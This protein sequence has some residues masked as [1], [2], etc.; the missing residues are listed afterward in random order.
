MFYWNPAHAV[1][2]INVESALRSEFSRENSMRYIIDV[3]AVGQDAGRDTSSVALV[4]FSNR[5]TGKEFVTVRVVHASMMVTD[6][7]WYGG[8]TIDDAWSL[9]ALRTLTPRRPMAGERHVCGVMVAYG[10]ATLHSC[11][12]WQA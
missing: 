4:T 11:E 9:F 2:A 12:H 3:I 5:H 1:A 6:A 7:R 8:D 10:G